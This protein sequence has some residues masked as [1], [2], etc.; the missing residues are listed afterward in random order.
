MHPDRVIDHP[1]GLLHFAELPQFLDTL[2]WENLPLHHTL[3]CTESVAPRQFSAHLF[4]QHHVQNN[5][6][7]SVRVHLSLPHFITPSFDFQKL[8]LV[9]ALW[10]KKKTTV[11][12]ASQIDQQ[13]KGAHHKQFRCFFP[14][15]THRTSGK[16]SFRLLPQTFQRR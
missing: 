7:F 15:C 6:R 16:P 9:G 5:H 1:F 2:N 8:F 3:Q 14:T 11:T 4:E 10:L 13:M 12:S